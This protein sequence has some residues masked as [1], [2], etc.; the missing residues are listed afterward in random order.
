MKK[1]SFIQYNSI[2]I[3]FQ[4]FGILLTL[5]II[6]NQNVKQIENLGR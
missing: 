6:M 1:K 3:F 5:L 4:T 2:Y